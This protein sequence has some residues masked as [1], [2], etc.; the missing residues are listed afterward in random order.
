M[1][2]LIQERPRFTTALQKLGTFGST[3]HQ[4]V[5][6]SQDDLVRNLRNLEPAIKALA[7]VGPTWRVCSNTPG[8]SRSRRASSTARSVVTTGTCSRPST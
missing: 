3:A 8:T 4:L 2:V 1:D 7:D 6:E 5:N